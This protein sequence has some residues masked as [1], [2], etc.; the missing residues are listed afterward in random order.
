M[1][2]D[3][4]FEGMT[5]CI[6]GTLSQLREN[7]IFY[8]SDNGGTV[9]NTVSSKTTYLLVGDN[10]GSSKMSGAKQFGTKIINEED[11]ENM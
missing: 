6:T 1:K 10:P 9:T 2:K 3:A 8:I 4:K 7:V 11:L 5:F